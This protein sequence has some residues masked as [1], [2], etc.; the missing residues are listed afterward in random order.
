VT[1]IEDAVVPV[2]TEATA[3]LHDRIVDVLG[4]RDVLPADRLTIRDAFDPSMTW[5]K[6][7]PEVRALIERYEATPTHFYEDP[8]DVPAQ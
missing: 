2:M 7:E 1:D 8:A 6:L 3:E 5:A 4:T